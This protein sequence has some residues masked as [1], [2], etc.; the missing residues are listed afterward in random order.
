MNNK[1]KFAFL[2]VFICLFLTISAFGLLYLMVKF[3]D[4]GTTLPILYF[5]FVLYFWLT[6][7]RTRAHKIEFRND[8]ILKREYFG[9]G[10]QRVFEIKNLEGF[11][12]SIQPDKSGFTEYIFIIQKG[13]R[14]AS[15][16]KFYHRNYKDMKSEIE[17]KIKNLGLKEYKFLYEYKEMFK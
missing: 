5:L 11:N 9:L 12:I 3:P 2:P 15:I 7:F 8:K 6:E 17:Q 16:S 4:S 10:K 13:K 14:I 1:S